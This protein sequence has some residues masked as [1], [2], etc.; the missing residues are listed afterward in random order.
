MRKARLSIFIVFIILVVSVLAGCGSSNKSVNTTKDT[1]RTTATNNNETK[2]GAASEE[3]ITLKVLRAGITVTEA[4]FE[5]TLVATTKA[6]FPHVT[7][8][9]VEAPEDVELEPLITSGEVPDLIFVATS[10]L[11]TTIADLELAEDLTPYVEKY[12]VDL[13]KLKPVVL[14]TIKQYSP[15]GEL[16]GFPFSVNLPVLFYNKDI[17]DKFSVNYPPDEQMSWN[18]AINLGKQVTRSD[19]GVNYIGIDLF[20]SNNISSGLDL[21]IVDP[22]TG[23]ANVTSPEWIK[24]FE[25]LQES[26]EVPGFI[27]ADG[28][29][30]Y[31]DDDDI[32]FNEQNVA[33]VAYNLAHLLGPLEELSQQGI[34]LNWDFAPFPNFE[35][36]LGTGKGANIHSIIMTKSSKHKDI[37]FQVL[38]NLLSDD[39]QL[40]LSKAGRVPTVEGEQF[41]EVY[42]QDIAV[43]EGKK[44]E[45]IFNAPPRKVVRPHKYEGKVRKFLAEAEQR[46]AAEGQDINTALRIAQ[47]AI[48]K[49]LETLSRTQ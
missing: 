27:G 8:E 38:A 21:T 2:D 16:H 5:K 31:A 43:L 9:W 1:T 17:F 10:N 23:T 6:K 18:E 35:E 3:P 34:E 24:V 29:Y 20:G 11:A 49:E 41:E 36:N 32:F 19:N 30:L 44:V 12:N 45:N 14:D 22:E 26:Y 15:E 48:D 13:S 46:V 28:R 25:Q 7:L 47:E 33:M 37:A 4:E 42:G 40:A 39:S